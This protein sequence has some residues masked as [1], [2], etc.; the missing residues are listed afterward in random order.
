[1]VAEALAMVAFALSG[2]IEGGPA[3]EAGI[4]EGD[5][6]VEFAGQTIANIY[7]YT[8]ALDAVKV[9]EP[10]HVVYERDGERFETVL[11]PR[12]RR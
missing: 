8:Y 11:T 10:I 6:I 3:D 4:Q 1:M 12:A 9:D 7:D 2:V 5:I